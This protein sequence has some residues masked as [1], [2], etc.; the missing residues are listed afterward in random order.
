M[1][2]WRHD[3][4]LEEGDGKIPLE[5]LVMQFDAPVLVERYGSWVKVQVAFY[6]FI[7][8]QALELCPRCVNESLLESIFNGRFAEGH[9]LYER[10]VA[11][12]EQ[13]FASQ[14]E[15]WVMFIEV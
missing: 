4:K 1:Q 14:E 7:F 13:R 3:T 9:D 2:C 5:R 10:H 8:G 15:A 6:D 12:I 11:F